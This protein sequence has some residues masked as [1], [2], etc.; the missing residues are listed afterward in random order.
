MPWAL[1][2]TDG[3][4][5]ALAKSYPFE[6]PRS[7]FL[8]RDGEAEPL[9]GGAALYCGRTPV[10]AHGSNR[11]PAHLRRKYGA[12]A[13]IPVSR[14]WLADYDVV[15]SAH[16]T[17]YGAIGAN[18]QHAPG[19]RVEVFITWLDEAQL[20]RMHETELANERYRYGR[21]EA[22]EITL[23]SGPA[24]GISEATAYLSNQGCLALDAAPVGLA[25][26]PAEGR[27]HGEM[28]Q[29]EAL[30]LVRDR[31][32][33]QRHLDAHILETIRD[34]AA[35]HALIAEMQAHAVPAAAPHFEVLNPR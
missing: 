10:V 25:A 18:L 22:V 11:S 33:P 21:L 3:E 1:P 24:A 9:G 14:A 31:H 27:P 23:E 20:V 4:L 12:S 15:Y 35:R 7:S 6:A 26:V 29:E 16:V 8:F 19:A 2:T 30:G 13:A 17:Q 32:R 5:V 28:G 34:A